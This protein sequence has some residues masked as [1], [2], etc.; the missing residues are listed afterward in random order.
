MAG[1]RESSSVEPR[2]L[3]SAEPESAFGV[4]EQGIGRRD[5]LRATALVSAGA[6]VPRWT[7]S[8]GAAEAAVMGRRQPGRRSGGRG[9]GILQPGRGHR[10]G[11]Y[12]RS[13]PRGIM[14]GRLPNRTTRPIRVVD[15]G[16]VLTFDTVSHEGLLEDQGRNPVRFFAGHGVREDR[17]LDDAKAIAAAPIPHDF[18][19]DGPHIVTGPVDVRGAQPGDVLMIDVVGLVPRVPYG[20]ISNR[21][22]RGALPEFPKTP[23]PEPGAGPDHP[24]RFHNVSVFTPVR[25]IR[26]LDRAVLPV[27]GGLRAEFPIDPFMGMMGVAL[28]TDQVVNSIPPTQAGGNIDIRDLRVGAKFYLPV[29]VPGAK[30]FVGD[31][32]FNQGNGEVALTALEASLRGTFRVTVLKRGSREIPGG[33][34]TLDMPFAETEEFWIAVG[35]NPDLD[36]AMQQCVR[37]SIAFLHGELGMAEAI[38]YAYLSAA[39]DYCVS[40]VVDRTKG[41]HARIR[42]HHFE[43]VLRG[44]ESAGRS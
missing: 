3:P 24:E 39:A 19:L 18:N 37:E 15:S 20:V 30:F 25:R 44:R 17:V 43:T 10:E 11:V 42:K 7:L 22:G 28:D 38:A 9:P 36:L 35:L 4:L 41:V 1:E 2:G 12:V 8:P 27:R 16:T 31:P 14:W 26:N 6:V 32:H 23:P 40:Q 29:F 13:T 33:R 34:G 21:H 5:L